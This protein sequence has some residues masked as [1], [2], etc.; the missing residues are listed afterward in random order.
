[1]KK[2]KFPNGGQKCY[3]CGELSRWITT[4]GGGISESYCSACKT[5][6]ICIT[7]RKDDE[8]GEYVHEHG[9]SKTFRLSIRRRYR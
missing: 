6:F 1:M 4:L 8:V 5:K 9:D 2:V 7:V 3:H